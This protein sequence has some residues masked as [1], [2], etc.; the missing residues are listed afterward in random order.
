MDP[1][2]VYV[3][4]GPPGPY[5][6]AAEMYGEAL[7]AANRPAEALTAFRES[8]RIYRRRTASLLGALRSAEALKDAAAA[9]AFTTTLREIW[10]A[11]DGDGPRIKTFASGQ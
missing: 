7:L 5:K 11:A 10:K 3:H 6:P 2:Q 1:A 8:L 4:F 9:T